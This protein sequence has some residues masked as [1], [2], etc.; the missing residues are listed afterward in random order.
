MEYDYATFFGQSLE[1]DN[2]A[3]RFEGLAVSGRPIRL[4]AALLKVCSLN[5]D[6]KHIV[7]M[8]SCGAH[9]TH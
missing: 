8:Y 6:H 4:R 2:F 1:L 3:S 9:N 5:H 7:H